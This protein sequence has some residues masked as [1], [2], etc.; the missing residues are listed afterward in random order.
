MSSALLKLF[1][2][3]V[4]LRLSLWYAVIFTVSSLAVFL[5]LYFLLAAA[6]NHSEREVIQARLKEYTAL[7]EAGGVDAL[8]RTVYGDGASPQQKS[9]F[10]RL[11]NGRNRVTFLSAPEDWVSFRDLGIG[12]DGYRRRLG[13]IRIP[14]DQERD[15]A[16]ASGLLPDGS[17]LQVGRSTNSRE[18]LLRPLRGLFLAATG[19]IVVF[20]FLAGAL[21][22][23]RALSPVRQMVTT[24][25]AIIETGQLGARVPSRQSDDELDEMARL[26]NRVL[27]QNQ[28]LLRAMREALDNV[29]HDLRTP[30]ARLRGHAEQALQ[31]TA[32]P[33]AT[34]E[35]LAECV[36]ESDRVLSILNTLMDV[37]EAEAGTMRLERAE[38][39]L[40][41]LV[42]E[43]VDVYEYVAEEKGVTLHNDC[44]APC[45][46][47][48]DANRIRQVFGNL[49][50]NAVK[51]T[52]A[53]GQ[54][55]IH[56]QTETGSVVARFRDTGMGIPA[57]EQDRIWARLYRG[58]RSRSQRGLGLGL[59]LVKAVVE[60]HGGR[61]VVVSRVG[62]GSEFTVRLPA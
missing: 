39:D 9:F 11:V 60:A 54:V 15:F 57:E 14:K 10:V 51:Y 40:C 35:A 20:G 48:V 36:E 17:L 32:S 5:L 22:A 6:L 31:E 16:I 47:R 42:A 55:W 46:A 2:R 62:E 21:F 53:G 25:R 7:Y 44:Q 41:R 19:G 50:D 18:L 33:A 8:R 27:D 56:T 1:R 12:W 4:G 43:V 24:A 61:V 28:A 58:D 30:L 52:P 38:V 49:L 26:F 34:R 23:H 37:A 29:A 13:V 59:S 3:H 45:P